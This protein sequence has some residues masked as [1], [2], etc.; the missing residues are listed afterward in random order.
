MGT[1]MAESEKMEAL[2]SL[3][4]EALKQYGWDSVDPASIEVEVFSGGS[5]NGTYKVSTTSEVTPSAVALH[6]RE[7][8]S[9][10]AENARIEAAAILFSEHGVSPKRCAQGGESSGMVWFIEPW[11]GGEPT[12]ANIDDMRVLG[13]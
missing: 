13:K 5:G 11:E 9:P 3:V 2:G 1:K 7:P 6:C 8:S 10:F 12:F 4:A